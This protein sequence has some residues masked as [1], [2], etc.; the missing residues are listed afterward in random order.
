MGGISPIVLS[1]IARDQK[2]LRIKALKEA[3]DPA[4]REPRQAGDMRVRA[5]LLEAKAELKRIDALR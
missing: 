3:A 1:W 4:G 2:R 5:R